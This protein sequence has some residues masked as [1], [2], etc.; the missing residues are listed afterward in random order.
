MMRSDIAEAI[1]GA[2]EHIQQELDGP[3]ASTI[4]LLSIHLPAD[5]T[6]EVVTSASAARDGAVNSV[7]AIT[8]RRLIF[9]APAPQAVAWRLSTVT[10]SQ[11]Y[12]GMFIIEGDAGQY[13][14]GLVSNEWGLK[15]ESLVKTAAAKAVLGGH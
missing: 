9:V 5:E 4:E 13:S 3:A 11:S 12:A 2:P 10:R 15:F 6:V 1:N 8:D 7:I 14:P